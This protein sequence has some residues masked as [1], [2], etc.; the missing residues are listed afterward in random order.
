MKTTKQ[1]LSQALMNEAFKYMADN[2]MENLPKLIDWAERIMLKKEYKQTAEMFRGIA[3]DPSNNWNQ[4]IQ[5][6]FTE[7]NQTTQRKF[8]I[9]YMVNAGLIGN[10]II[11]KSKIKYNCNVPWAILLDP[12]AAC[13]LS[14]TGCWA[15]EY[16]KGLS[17][18]YATMQKVVRQGKELG[19]YMYIFSGGEPTVRKDVLIRLA[20]E[21]S[22]CMFL[23]FTNATLIDE[24]F[25]SAIERV[26]NF[27]FA[28]SV[29]GDE[30][31]TDMRRG[32]GT[33]R[34]V[35]EAMDI[36]QKHGIIFGFSA[37][38]HRKNTESVGGEEFVDLMIEK[39]CKFGWYF[40][41]VPIGKDAVPELLAT[42]EQRE[43]MY[44]QI[45]RF[46]TTKPCFLLDFWNDGEYVEGC[47][48]GGRKYL[49]INSNGDVEPCAFIH[50]DNPEMLRT[51]VSNSGAHSTQFADSETAE[52]L[53]AK[54]APAAE[55]WE[56]VADR[57]W[58]ESHEE[59]DGLLEAK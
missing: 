26:G 35:M 32:R 47:I 15:A 55:R 13:N 21:N 39:G 42:P 1:L 29:E 56:P 25:A 28:I 11:E 41:Y 18:D 45:R 40:T 12:T 43:Y 24:E 27:G 54:T 7:L 53:T 5:R 33:Y 31:E 30:A 6:Y 19:I 9:N 44:R 52:E 2:P 48:A 20:E 51:M 3:R 50:Y 17:L 22:D 4:L 57:L 59:V 14:C 46:R 8:L 37:C 10:A 16:G 38:Y 34:K 23:S 58:T 36:L 49:H